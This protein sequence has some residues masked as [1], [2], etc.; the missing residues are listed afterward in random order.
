[1]RFQSPGG[2]LSGGGTPLP[3][4]SGYGGTRGTGAL[5]NQV[6]VAFV[7]QYFRGGMEAISRDLKQLNADRA[8]AATKQEQIERRLAAVQEGANR[9]QTARLRA[10][11]QAPILAAQ[12]EAQLK[13]AAVEQKSLGAATDLTRNALAGTL[14]LLKQKVVITGREAIL[15]QSE[16]GLRE[17]IVVLERE[18]AAAQDVVAQKQAE[19]NALTREQATLANFGARAFQSLRNIAV[20]AIGATVGGVV[21]GAVF[22]EPLQNT[23]KAIGELLG[24]WV[25]PARAAR[26]EVEKIAGAI[27]SIASAEKVS[28]LQAA[29]DLLRQLG[30]AQPGVAAQGLAGAP[31]LQDQQ[32]RID[33]LKQIGDYLLGQAE[34]QKQLNREESLALAIVNAHNAGLNDQAR[35]LQALQTIRSIP[36]FDQLVG[37]LPLLG[38]G[39]KAFFDQ[40]DTWLGGLPRGTGNVG[41]LANATDNAANAAKTAADA[42][43]EMAEAVAKAAIGAAFDAQIASLEQARDTAISGVQQGYETIIDGIRNSAAAAIDK[44]SADADSR[45]SRLEARIKAV[46]DQGPSARTGSLSDQINAVNAAEEKRR[47]NLQLSDIAEQRSL[48]LLR[49]RLALTTK[50]IDLTEY[51]GKARLVAIDALLARQQEQNAAQD[52]FN[53]LLDIQYQINQGVRR[54]QGE[55]IQDFI[56]RRAQYYRGL[57]EQ[58]ASLQKQGPEA[59]LKAERAR[60]QTTLELRDLEDRRTELLRNRAHQAYLKRLQDELKASQDADR[61]RAQAEQERLRD[62]IARIRESTQSQIE[63]INKARDSDIQAAERARD[64]RIAAIKA[65]TQVTIDEL[66][67]QREATIGWTNSAE[68]ARYTIAVQGAQN[69]AQLNAI[70]GALAGANFSAAYVEAQLRALGFV[71]TDPTWV[72]TMRNFNDTL[73][74]YERQFRNL[75]TGVAHLGGFGGGPGLGGF[76]EGGLIP[77]RNSNMLGSDVRWGERG[78]EGGLDTPHG[79]MVFNNQIMSQLRQMDANKTSFGGATF[80]V[81]GTGDFYGDRY[82]LKQM[83]KEVIRETLN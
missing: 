17:G 6:L 70:S 44:I 41:D 56:N 18:Q 83:I 25:D 27:S 59:E 38:P 16:E 55:T 13:R 52:R 12:L 22:F 2:N 47:F 5:V 77:L 37:N 82:R 42:Y 43:R 7:T 68:A 24:E 3:R 36:L 26:V 62:Q 19:I 50:D 14:D 11:N 28:N 76:A 79:R 9:A 65:G 48:I 46:G 45:I 53:K 60:T 1:M 20:A 31:S 29:V 63:A 81:Q 15:I 8:A 78:D 69:L 33:T 23:I 4:G 34:A 58:A 30:V 66:K 32:G 57:L 21:L 71:P 64:S 40:F 80:N 51:S 54:Q 73:A 10:A 39:Y 74:A 67:K 72:T 75:T 49:E 61:K 35:T